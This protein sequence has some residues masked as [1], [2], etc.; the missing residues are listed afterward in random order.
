MAKRKR[1]PKLT[2]EQV[3][4]YFKKQGDKL[5]TGTYLG[6]KQP[7]Q[8]RCGG[9]NRIRVAVFNNY[10]RGYRCHFC[11]IKKKINPDAETTRKVVLR[12][13]YFSMAE[14]CRLFGF[15]YND[16]R[17]HVVDKKT[18]PAPTK[19]IGLKKYYTEE[20][21]QKIRDLVLLEDQ[22]G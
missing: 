19:K 14:V 18:L 21:L 17:S 13:Q 3:R 22:E 12:S 16:F 4:A 9:C 2:T 15:R 6:T 1:R 8:Y 5:L 10:S 20:D 11:A 7:L